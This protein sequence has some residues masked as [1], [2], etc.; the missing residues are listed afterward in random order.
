MTSLTLMVVARS[1]LTELAMLTIAADVV[2]ASVTL[3]KAISNKHYR[4]PQKYVACI[5]N[6]VLVKVT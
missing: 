2:S 3:G 5:I 1:S 6:L 4:R